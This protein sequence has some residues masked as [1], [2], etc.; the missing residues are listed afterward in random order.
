MGHARQAFK[1]RNHI[2]KDLRDPRFR[3]RVVADACQKE[4]NKAVDYCTSCGEEL[5]VGELCSCDQEVA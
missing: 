4:R 2:A 3:M 1:K 5:Q